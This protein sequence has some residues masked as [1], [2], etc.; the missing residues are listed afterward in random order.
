MPRSTL[1]D[2]PKP[3]R[4]AATDHGQDRFFRSGRFLQ[5][6]PPQVLYASRRSSQAFTA[7]LPQVEAWRRLNDAYQLL[8][9]L[10]RQQAEQGRKGPILGKVSLPQF[11]TH[12]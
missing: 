11:K 9:E 7:A 6:H 5:Q 3:V 10:Y 1:Y 8:K 4:E 2:R 12:A